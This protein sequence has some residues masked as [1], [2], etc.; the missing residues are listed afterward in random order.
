MNKRVGSTLIIA[1]VIL[2]AVAGGL[3]THAWQ[4]FLKTPLVTAVQGLQYQV[5]FGSSYKN[6]S[7]ELHQEHILKYPFMFNLLFR[8]R[9]DTHHLKA[10][11]YLFPYGSTPD[12]MVDQMV[13]GTGLILHSFTIVPGMNFRQLRQ[14]LLKDHALKHTTSSLSNAAIMKRLG[15]SQ[16][17]PEGLFFPDTYYFVADTSD[18]VILKS[19]YNSMQ[20]KLTKAWNNRG[21]NLPIKTPYEALI[22]AS[23]IEKEADIKDE[24]PIIAGVLM[25]RLR[26]DIILQFDPTVIYGEGTRFNGTIYRRD[27]LSKNNLYNTYIHK[28]LTPTPISMPSM[29]AIDA[30]MH[31]DDNNYLYFVAR[32]DHMTHQFSQTLA[33]HNAAVKAAKKY[34]SGYFNYGLVRE[35]LLKQFNKRI[36]NTN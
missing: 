29:E 16:S 34:R 36:F 5:H 27:L 21:P 6:V 4:N 30:V 33:D 28:G 17:N 32:G 14:A 7:T 23:I 22:A 35:Y 31:P 8:I 2:L 12:K 1:I 11:E 24:L 10:G 19:A 26:R 9:G 3:F 18:L 20:Q 25:N 15:D 13:N